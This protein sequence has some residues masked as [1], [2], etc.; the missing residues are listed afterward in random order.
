MLEHKEYDSLINDYMPKFGDKNS[1]QIIIKVGQI[2]N[3]EN[4][5]QKIIGSGRPAKRLMIEI[6]RAKKVTCH[7]INSQKQPRVI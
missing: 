3:M 4:R 2:K 7:L 5:L 6:E 1:T